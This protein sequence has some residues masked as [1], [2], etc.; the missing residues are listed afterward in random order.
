[1]LNYGFHC[2]IGSDSTVGEEGQIKEGKKEL[3]R[4]LT[5]ALAVCI[6]GKCRDRGN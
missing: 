4:Q 6:T 5:R 1:M 3:R 2:Q